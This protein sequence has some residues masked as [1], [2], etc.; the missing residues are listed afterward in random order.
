MEAVWRTVRSGEL[1]GMRWVRGAG[2]DLG[3]LILPI[4]LVLALF[5]LD[6]ATQGVISAVA[7]GSLLLSGVH[8]A[9]NWTLLFR[10]QTFYKFDRMRYVHMGWLIMLGSIVLS[11][12][13]LSLFMSVY[14]Y[15]GLWHFARQH[16]GI[17]ML[18]K[19]KAQ[20]QNRAE[21]LV[22][23]VCAHLL[24]FL[25]LFAQFARPGDF[26]FYTITLYRFHLPEFFANACAVLWVVVFFGWLLYCAYRLGQGTLCL[27]F[28]LTI[29]L[30]VISF[31]A[32]Y[33]FVHSFLLMYVMISIPHS[34]Q[35]IGLAL[36]YHD[37][38]NKR[39]RKWGLA[40]RKR[41]LAGFWVFTIGYTILAVVLIRINEQVHSPLVYGLLGLT[42]FHFWVELFSWRPKHNPELRDSLG[43]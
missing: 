15:W 37:G 40:R 43:I 3:W 13:N 9:T 10:D 36:Y 39:V 33:F 8:I 5:P 29:L 31:G 21:Y 6:H 7:L 26:G 30:A 14:V 18:Y 34:L 1:W 35:Y 20:Q 16:W 23:K 32:I 2:Y 11:W 22:D 17:A 27:P 28:F 24:M 38:K 25:P 42:I 4:V 19:A 12:W 41:F